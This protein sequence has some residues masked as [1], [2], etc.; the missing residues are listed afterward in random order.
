M[1]PG[2]GGT[3]KAHNYFAPEP[4]YPIEIA[5][6]TR[7]VLQAGCD[8]FVTESDGYL[9]AD[10]VPGHSILLTCGLALE[11]SCRRKREARK[12][13]ARFTGLGSMLNSQP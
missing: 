13:Q 4:H 10:R 2:C 12:H 5:F 7:E 3:G 8:S 1:T 11:A 9:T 6:D